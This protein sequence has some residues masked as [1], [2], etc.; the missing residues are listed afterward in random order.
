MIKTYALIHTMQK[1]EGHGFIKMLL[2]FGGIFL[3]AVI[4]GRLIGKGVDGMKD[5]D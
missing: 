1:I 4:A 2:F 3:L 5:D